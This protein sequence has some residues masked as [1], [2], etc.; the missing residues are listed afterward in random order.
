M[1]VIEKLIHI[2][3][4]FLNILF[5]QKCVGCGAK[6]EIFCQ[7]CLE[8]LPSAE[9]E[10]WTSKPVFG[11]VFAATSYRN[12]TVK[13]AIRLLKYHGIKVMAEPLASLIFERTKNEIL[14]IATEPAEIT[15]IPIP[16]SKSRL[17]KR[18]Y[19]QTELIA[20]FLS[21]KLSVRM[22]TNVLYKA[23]ETISQVEI[24]DREKRLKNIQGTFKVRNPESIKNKIVILIDDIV[25]TGATLKEAS[26]MLKQSGAKK[27]IG[28]V[29]AR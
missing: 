25:T 10:I 28:L 27:V 2:F 19:N 7:K 16:L 21:D 6:N 11:P 13:K 24:K 4:A 14:K 3:K 23:K 5:P 22:G 17:R 8:S 26:I 20:N 18:G 1:A 12:E 15:I 9:S 29:V